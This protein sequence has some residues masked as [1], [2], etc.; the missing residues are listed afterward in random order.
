MNRNI[1][2][3]HAAQVLTSL[4]PGSIDLVIT[5]PPY[6]QSDDGSSYDG[7]ISDLQSVWNECARVLRPNGKL[8]INAPIMPVPKAV[9]QQ[10]TRA[11]KNIAF[12]IEHRILTE[13]DLELYSL[14]VWQKQTSKMMFGSYPY[15]G[16]P[17][18]NNTIEFINIYVKPGKPPKF[19]R[20]RE[21]CQQDRRRRVA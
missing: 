10:H 7:Y 1:I 15:P 16:N 21:G 17:I 19:P 13:T 3:G 14:F 9:I 2:C 5:S 6:W 12:D 8:C 20:G 11:L 4:C 18:E